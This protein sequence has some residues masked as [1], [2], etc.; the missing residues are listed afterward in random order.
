MTKNS[1]S[2]LQQ[3]IAALERECAAL[4]RKVSAMSAQQQRQEKIDE[5]NRQL[6]KKSND[7]L[8]QY[9]EPAQLEN[10]SKSDFLANMSHEI[11][12]PLNI[13]LGMANLLAETELDKAQMQYLSSLRVTGRQLMEILNNVLEFSRIE[14]GKITIEP[15]PF[16]AQLRH[17]QRN[18]YQTID[19]ATL[20]RHLQGETP[21][22]VW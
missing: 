18:G 10:I 7:K 12:T 11:R 3:K 15:E 5:I 19:G 1:Q 4:R 2:Y 16:E 8:L 9:H 20:L 6:L 21:S 17:L 14:A 22:I 13:I